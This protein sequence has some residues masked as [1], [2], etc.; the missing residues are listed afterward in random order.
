MLAKRTSWDSH[1]L[2]KVMNVLSTY[3]TWTCQRCMHDRGTRDFGQ[4]PA[5][6]RGQ[7]IDQLISCRWAHFLEERCSGLWCHVGQ[8]MSENPQYSSP[9]WRRKSFAK[10]VWWFGQCLLLLKNQIFWSQ[11]CLCFFTRRLSELRDEA[12]EGQGVPV[13]AQQPTILPLEEDDV[14]ARWLWWINTHVYLNRNS[15]FYFFK[16]IF[17]A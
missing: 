9:F 12:L 16:K 6:H 11:Q 14:E 10:I 7:R 13:A 2:V 17:F 1:I 8:K 15:F 3:R 4:S 5:R